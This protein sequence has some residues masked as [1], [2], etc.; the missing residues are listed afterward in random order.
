MPG[1]TEATVTT[2]TAELKTLVIGSRQVTIGIWNQLDRVHPDEIIPFG[3][4]SPPGNTEP[5][6]W[7][8]GKREVD[9]T[10]VRSSYPLSYNGRRDYMASL[11][12][13][14]GTDVNGFGGVWSDEM[15]EEADR[16][17]ENGRVIY[18]RPS[19]P[20]SPDTPP[21]GKE[22]KVLER[23]YHKGLDDLRRKAQEQYRQADDE[24]QEKAAQWQALDLIVL[25]GLGLR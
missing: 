20:F 25:A 17:F 15:R 14:A 3:R 7:V 24:L 2:I 9:G 13:W 22:K 4:I 5:V 12:G 16:L 1:R 21:Q 18:R 10:L 8:V 23:E 19:G 11:P 6:I